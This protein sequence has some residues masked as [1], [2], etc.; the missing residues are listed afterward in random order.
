MGF[1]S[2][3]LILKSFFGCYSLILG[4]EM[5]VTA[6]SLKRIVRSIV[7]IMTYLGTVNALI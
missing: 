6:R 2:Y 4:D 1:P 7:P 3:K 5:N